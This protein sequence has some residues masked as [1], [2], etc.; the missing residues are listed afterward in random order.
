MG[1]C[2]VPVQAVRDLLVP[3]GLAA[4]IVAF[5][6]IFPAV[7]APGAVLA[8]PAA[9]AR[10]KADKR[11]C[12]GC[13]LAGADLSHTCVKGG[14]LT[15][16]NFDRVNAHYMCMSRANFTNVTFRNA[17]L[18]GANLANS[19]M[20]GA[21]LTGAVLEITSLKGTDLSHARGLTQAQLDQACSDAA[22]R[23]PAGLT[24]KPCT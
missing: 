5:A 4:A 14:D 1:E 23:L 12:P 7:A 15:G 3:I 8:D 18:T 20:T 21:D 6:L 2:P 19:N 17:D 11:D 24:G 9:V 22:T 10:V 16:A 13:V